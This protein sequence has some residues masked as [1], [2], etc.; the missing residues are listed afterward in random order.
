MIQLFKP[1]ILFPILGTCSFIPMVHSIRSIL[2]SFL[3]AKMIEKAIQE[4][5]RWDCNKFGNFQRRKIFY[6]HIFSDASVSNLVHW[7]QIMEEEE[8]KQYNPFLHSFW[9]KF[10]TQFYASTPSYP[11]R[12]IKTDLHLFCGERDTISD[13][14]FIKAYL[15]IAQIHLINDYEHMDFLFAEC[16]KEKCYDGVIQILQTKCE[17]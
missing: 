13:L 15:P 9:P 4:F 17:T 14:E 12:H 8:F 6:A 3:Y 11:L 7:F 2:P 10:P 5:F 16:A 1:K